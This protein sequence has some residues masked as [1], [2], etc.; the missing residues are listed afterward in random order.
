MHAAWYSTNGEAKDVL[1]VGELPTPV[2]AA[3]QVRVRLFASGV[4]PSDV[5]S[6]R[7]RALSDQLII[8]HSDGAGVIEA[9]GDETLAHRIG[10]RVWIWNGQWQRAHG[11]AAAMIVVPSAQAVAL[12]DGTGFAEGACLGIPAL[13]AFQAIRLL[14]DVQG[15]TVLVVG[16]ASAVGHYAAQMAVLAGAQVIGTVGSAERAQHALAAGVATTI[17][18]KKENVAD[19]V[20]ALT[21][22][23]GADAI[24]DMDFSS[25]AALL[26]AGALAAHGVV[27]CYGSNQNGEVG[28]PF[29][30]ALFGSYTIRFFLVYD[31]TQA[32]RQA[33]IAG[34]QAL[35]VAGRLRHTVGARFPLADIVS[36][37]EAVE[38]GRIIGNV[39]LDLGV[40]GG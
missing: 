8:P 28:I 35:L 16:A 30:A 12:P 31:L 38:H 34:L 10:E 33:A 7:G 26:G 22:G 23:R 1:T 15:K 17:D 11:T 2:P 40:E 37:H 24:V 29:R 5:K 9:A 19:R 36:A 3:G 27:A 21:G 39:V 13:T 4:N 14:G 32:D 25:T 6:R 18:Y 20:R